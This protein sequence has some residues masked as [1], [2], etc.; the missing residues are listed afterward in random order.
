MRTSRVI[1]SFRL[2]EGNKKIRIRGMELDPTNSFMVMT[3]KSY[4]KLVDRWEVG[5]NEILQYDLKQHKVL[6]KIPWPNNEEREFAGFRFSPDGKFLY[7]FGDDIIAYDTKD[8]KEVDK[9]E[10]SKP[11]EDG[12]GRINFGGLDDSYEDPGYLSGIFMVQDAV[13]NRRMMGIGR[14][15]LQQKKVD[16]YP[17]GPASGVSFAMAPDR[18][19]AYGLHQEIGKYE[20]W[21]FD[22]KNHKIHSRTEFEGRPRM[23]L[24]PSTNGKLL[25]IYQA[26]RTIDV[27]EAAT[28]KH[29]R[30]IELDSDMNGLLLLDPPK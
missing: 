3:A 29:L 15:N 18:Q 12:F 10:L 17:L 24:K 13:Q 1:D 6:R 7:M 23:Q 4:T 5:A 20:F 8:F 25:Y 11:Y 28:Y 16:F 26:G 27:Y 21:T 22:L 9:W 30:T 2:S 14:V 19:M